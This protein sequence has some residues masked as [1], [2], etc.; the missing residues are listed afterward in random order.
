MMPHGSSAWNCFP[1]T[2]VSKFFANVGKSDRISIDEKV[3]IWDF[4][5]QYLKPFGWVVSLFSHER[6]IGQG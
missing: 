2:A 6:A 3:P 1:T 5:E 4:L